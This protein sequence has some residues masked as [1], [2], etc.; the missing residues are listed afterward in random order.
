MLN[1]YH[2]RQYSHL[3]THDVMVVVGV[4]RH[5]QACRTSIAKHDRRYVCKTDLTLF[6]GSR[7]CAG[8]I[9][10]LLLICVMLCS[11]VHIQLIVHAFCLGH[12]P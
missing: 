8:N 9:E 3:P 2:C 7:L 5:P 10:I 12:Q 1:E 6:T 11:H 4:V